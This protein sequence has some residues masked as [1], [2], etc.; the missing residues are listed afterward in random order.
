[1]LIADSDDRKDQICTMCCAGYY[2]ETSIHD[3]WDEMLHCTNKKCNHEVKRYK[4][5]DDPKPQPEL[6]KSKLSFAAKA[7]LDA[8]WQEIDYVL[9]RHVQWAAAAALY[10]AADQVCPRDAI[11]PRNYLPMAIENDRIRREL[12]AIADELKEVKYGTYRCNLEEK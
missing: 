4:W 12:F 11:E 3:D 1:M 2:Q 10:A 5:K 6:V 9:L 8:T 7:V